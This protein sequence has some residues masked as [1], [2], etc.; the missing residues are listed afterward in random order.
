VNEAGSTG[1]QGGDRIAEAG[2]RPNC[3]FRSYLHL[4]R[5]MVGLLRVFVVLLAG[6]VVYLW[7]GI[8]LRVLIRFDRT[9]LDPGEPGS[10]LPID[11]AVTFLYCL[12]PIGWVVGL[13]VFTLALVMVLVVHRWP[14]P[15]RVIVAVAPLALLVRQMIYVSDLHPWV[16]PVCLQIV[17]GEMVLAVLAAV[18]CRRMARRLPR[19]V[20]PK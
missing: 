6:F 4:K 11:Y 15:L 8:S 2:D 10:G 1:E 14:W 19:W 13:G 7:S 18:L 9:G 5:L 17:A 20:V 16:R 12:G 3:F